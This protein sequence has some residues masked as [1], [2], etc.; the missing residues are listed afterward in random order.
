MSGLRITDCEASQDGGAI[1]LKH[2]LDMVIS[3]S[4]INSNKASDKGGGIYFFCIESE[5]DSCSL[6][7]KNT[8]IN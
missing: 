8:Q 5:T 1:Y 3:D 7:L 6:S 4:I 2:I